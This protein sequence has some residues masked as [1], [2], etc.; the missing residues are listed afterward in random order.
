MYLEIGA[1]SELILATKNAWFENPFK[2]PIHPFGV[3]AAIYLRDENDSSLRSGVR[4]KL[5]S[6]FQIELTAKI[7]FV[8]DAVKTIRL[9]EQVKAAG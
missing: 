4:K 3:S 1:R 8:A 6:G 7:D 9:T 2:T 5:R